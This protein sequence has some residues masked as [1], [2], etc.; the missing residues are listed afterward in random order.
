M[1]DV[2]F[3]YVLEVELIMKNRVDEHMAKLSNSNS[4]PAG[5]KNQS[6]LKAL[7][8]IEYLAR[9]NNEPKRLHDIA[10]SLSMNA[11]TVSRFLTSLMERG[12]I[13][14]EPDYPR[15]SLSMKLCNLAARININQS[16]Y[17]IALPIMKEISHMVQESVCIA[18]EQNSMVEYIGF[19]QSSDQILRTM[20]RI[21][22]RAP[23][24]CTGIGKL[25]LCNYTPAQLH[26]H[27]EKIGLPIFTEYTIATEEA[28]I[29]ELEIIRKRQY[30]FDNQECEVGARCIAAPITDSN[31]RI[32]AGI[33]ITGPFFRLTDE[34]IQSFLPYF[35]AQAKKI[36]DMLKV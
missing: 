3:S 36:S 26:F 16:L 28:L 9:G 21:G 8:I 24:H 22:S 19:V 12:Y 1:L 5:I 20:Q 10:N 14:Q 25:L 23:M 4:D 29:A 35:L 33:S 32:V 17:S 27:V 15:Y 34:K 7:D 13:Y 6:V 11:S 18:V 31:H 2:P 30:S